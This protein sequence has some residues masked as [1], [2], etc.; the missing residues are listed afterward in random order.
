LVQVLI[1]KLME[2][3]ALSSIQL[4]FWCATFCLR[5]SNNSFAPLIEHALDLVLVLV[6][7]NFFGILADEST[8]SNMLGELEKSQG[9]YFKGILPLIIQV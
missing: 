4:M 6:H 8:Y 5:T 9:W 7:A 3:N 2:Q 1:P